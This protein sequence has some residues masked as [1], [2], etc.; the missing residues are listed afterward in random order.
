MY[1]SKLLYRSRLSL[2]PQ[3]ILVKA[4]FHISKKG[5]EMSVQLLSKER[6]RENEKTQSFIQSIKVQNSR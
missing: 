6:E 3:V 2:L 1:S 4:E 5:Q